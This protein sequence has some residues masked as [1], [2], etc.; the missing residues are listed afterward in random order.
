MQKRTILIIEDEPHLA[1][2]LTAALV[3]EGFAVKSAADGEEGLRLV[4]EW[5][6]AVVVLDLILPKLDGFRV[7]EEV[8]KDKRA[9]RI[10]VI[11]LS[12]LETTENIERA[13]GLGAAAYLVKPN[14]ELAHIVDKIKAT[15]PKD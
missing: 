3:E 1:E 13:V 9:S 2:E 6:P 12:N 7:L 14:Y 5:H 15:V 8:K 10:P 4:R 11:V